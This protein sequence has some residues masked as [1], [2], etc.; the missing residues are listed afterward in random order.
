MPQ[1][2]ADLLAAV[3]WIPEADRRAEAEPL[4][5]QLQTIRAGSRRR[6]LVLLGDILPIVLKRLGVGTVQSEM[7]EEP[8][9]G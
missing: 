6:G 5:E 3:R 8:S 1:R 7:S 2:R 4:G 9:P